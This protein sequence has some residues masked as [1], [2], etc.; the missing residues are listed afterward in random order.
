MKPFKTIVVFFFS[1][2]GVYIGFYLLASMTNFG[3]NARNFYGDTIEKFYKNISSKA[4]IIAEPVREEKTKLLIKI[5][6]KD[7]I[8]RARDYYKKTGKRLEGKIL[9]YY[10]NAHTNFLMPLF[11][12][13]SLILVYPCGFRRKIQALIIGLLLMAVY[14]YFKAGCSLIYTIDQ[15]QEF[16]PNYELSPYSN[17]FLGLIEGLFIETA[18]I[19]A[20]LIWLLVCVRIEDFKMLTTVP[21]KKKTKGKRKSGKK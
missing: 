8:K 17:K 16:F 10:T 2:L 18:Y 20:V 5:L 19:L 6:N 15:S 7:E 14:I 3:S 11:F 1:F 12:L 9:A 13:A 21:E 4:E